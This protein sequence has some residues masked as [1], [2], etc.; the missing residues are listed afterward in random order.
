MYLGVKA[1][2]AKSFERIHMANLVNFGIVPLVFENPADY[3]AIA[4][5][6]ELVIEGFKKALETGGK[7]VVDFDAKVC[8]MIQCLP[9]VETSGSRSSS[10]TSVSACPDSPADIVAPLAVNRSSSGSGAV[11]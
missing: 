7:V 5:G 6:D 9:T 8:S 1:V 10:S 2:V 3:D 4:Q 11:C